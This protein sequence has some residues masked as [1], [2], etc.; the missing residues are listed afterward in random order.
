MGLKS[1]FRI[2][3]TSAF[4]VLCA[5]AAEAQFE[6]YTPPGGPQERPETREDRL[7]REITAAHYH[8]GPVKIAPQAGIRDVSYVRNLFGSGNDASSD[9]TAT[10]FA[11]AHA[12]LHTGRKVTWIAHALPQYVWWSR[13]ADARRLNLTYGLEEVG[14]FNRLFLGIAANREESQRFIT[15]E[16]PQ[17]FSFRTDVLQANAEVKL[18]GSIYAFTAVRRTGQKNL[19][20]QTVVPLGLDLS[21]LDR[22]ELV[23]REGIRWRPA[24]GWTLGLGAEQ[25]RT[26]FDRKAGD[27]SNS[28]TAPVLEMVLDRTELVTREG[29]RWRPAPGWTLGL[30]AE[31]SR[32]DFDHKASDSSSSGTAPV[33]EMVLDRHFVFLQVDAAARSLKARNGSRFASFDGL[34]GSVGA[35]YRPQRN[36]EFWAYGNRSL[37]YSLSTQYPYLEDRRIG[38]ALR[39]GAGDRM[40]SRLFVETGTN[41]YTAFSADTPR[42]SDDVRSYGALMRFA[43]TDQLNMVFQVTRSKYVSNIAA[44]SRSYTAGGVTVTFGGI[45]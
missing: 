5:G 6:Q 21:L 40:S 37:M 42:R 26:D 39:M 20:K 28:G 12:Y 11:G 14:L 30:G 16:V 22:T 8:L 44:N 43:A 33:L 35:S 15:P 45:F 31:Q 13:R 17:L 24:P 3:S 32:T 29:I 41:D 18:T 1:R 9:V 38:V 34:T 7:K 36:L 19:V 27:S 23:T 2:C 4:L 10:A 25:S